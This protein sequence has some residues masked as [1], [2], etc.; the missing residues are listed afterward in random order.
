MT[1][2]VAHNKPVFPFAK[3]YVKSVLAG[4]I[5]FSREDPK[6]GSEFYAELQS[7][8]PNREKYCEL[9]D[10]LILHV[11]SRA[12]AISRAI[13]S[14]ETMRHGFGDL[15]FAAVERLTR[16]ES[17]PVMTLRGHYIWGL[18]SVMPLPGEPN[19]SLQEMIVIA[20]T[21]EQELAIRDGVAVAQATSDVI[22]QQLRV[23]GQNTS[24]LPPEF[25]EWLFGNRNTRCY[26]S[27]VGIHDH[28]CYLHENGIHCATVHTEDSSTFLAIQPH[29]SG[30]FPELEA[31]LIPIGEK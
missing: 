7:L 24:H 16:S 10:S 19:A 31:T 4:L 18:P 20:E 6:F 30:S 8:T 9:D 29:A 17:Q 26:R 3:R 27:S 11:P 15:L 28:E 2:S 25:H 5:A 22:A 23:S 13:W 14:L 21:D 1:K 12:A